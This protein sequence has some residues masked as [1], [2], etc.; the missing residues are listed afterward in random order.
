MPA[1]R[2]GRREERKRVGT[3]KETGKAMVEKEG[4]WGGAAGGSAE[5]G[6]ESVGGAAHFPCRN[7]RKTRQSTPEMINNPLDLD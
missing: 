3:A 4:D 7:R 6:E 1:A 2:E 5:K